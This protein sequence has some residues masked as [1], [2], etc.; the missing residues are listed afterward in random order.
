MPSETIYGTDIALPPKAIAS[1]L[2]RS[3]LQTAAASL[4]LIEIIQ[5]HVPLT[6]AMDVLD[7]GCG[8]GKLAVALKEFKSEDTRYV[9]F[10]IDK[11]RMDWCN[12]TLGPRISNA[13]FMFIDV[14]NSAYKRAGKRKGSNTQ[15]PLDDDSFDFVYAHSVFSHM[16][17]PDIA[18]Y[19]H[20]IK[21]VMRPG[22]WAYLT[23]LLVDRETVDYFKIAEDP[24]H[25]SMVPVG[26]MN[27]W[28]Y[29][30]KAKFVEQCIAVNKGWMLRQADEA[31]LVVEKVVRGNWRRDN[32]EGGNEIYKNMQDI[33]VIRNPE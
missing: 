29:A 8:V 32:P 18:N 9:G 26:K 15:F 27:N 12:E 22:A 33:L 2:L 28:W 19:M 31:G 7:I 10:D 24:L 30:S 14:Y 3:R 6:P 11:P 20:E 25:R 13:E 1:Q 4:K 5:R 17:A 16:N 23:C 21:R